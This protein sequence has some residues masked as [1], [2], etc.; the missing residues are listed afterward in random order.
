MEDQDCARKFLEAVPMA[1][2]LIK[3]EMRATAKSELTVPQFRLFARLARSSATSRE[4]A[5]WMGVTPPTISRMVESLM[6]RKL[7][8]RGARGSDKRHIPLELTKQGK[9]KYE[10]IRSIVQSI[11]SEKISKLTGLQKRKLVEGLQ[12]VGSLQR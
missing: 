9:M 6:A 5:Q 7:I 4:L 10:S 3:A 1:M 2:R 8:K 12:I 11:F